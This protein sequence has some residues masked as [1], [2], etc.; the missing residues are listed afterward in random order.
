MRATVATA[1]SKICSTQTRVKIHAIGLGIVAEGIVLAKWQ[2][3]NQLFTVLDALT[4]G[5]SMALDWRELLR[6]ALGYRRTA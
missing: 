1:D 2:V 4:R 3:I 5:V 6:A